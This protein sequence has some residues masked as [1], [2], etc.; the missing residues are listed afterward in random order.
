MGALRVGLKIQNESIDEDR[1]GR[2]EK[3]GEQ[4]LGGRGRGHPGGAEHTLGTQKLAASPAAGL[5]CG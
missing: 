2:G 3:M 5:V 4:N 1:R